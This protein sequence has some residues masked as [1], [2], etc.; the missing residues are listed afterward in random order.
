MVERSIVEILDRGCSYQL[1]HAVGDSVLE[2]AIITSW[3][4]SDLEKKADNV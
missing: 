3:F 4:T 2:D 1:R